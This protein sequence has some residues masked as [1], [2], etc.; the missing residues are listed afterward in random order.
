MKIDTLEG[1]EIMIKGNYAKQRLPREERVS[2]ERIP[3]SGFRI[4]WVGA[5]PGECVGKHP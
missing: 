4:L 2:L 5:S 1:E 3:L